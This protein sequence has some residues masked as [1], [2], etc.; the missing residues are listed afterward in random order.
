MADAKQ[1]LAVGGHMETAGYTVAADGDVLFTGGTLLI[2]GAIVEG[3]VTGITIG[4]SAAT[5]PAA[6]AEGEVVAAAASGAGALSVVFVS[7]PDKRYVTHD[8]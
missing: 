2:L 3:A 6:V 4:G 5:F 1:T 7:L 8:I